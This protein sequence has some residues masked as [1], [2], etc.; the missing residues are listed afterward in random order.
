MENVNNFN[1]EDGCT[2]EDCANHA[3]DY[4]IEIECL[5]DNYALDGSAMN[6][7]ELI[8]NIPRIADNIRGIKTMYR[9]LL[10]HPDDVEN[11]ETIINSI[12]NLMDTQFGIE[13]EYVDFETI[14]R[15]DVAKAMC[16]DALNILNEL[17]MAC[18]VNNVVNQ[19]HNMI[20]KMFGVPDMESAFGLEP[21][22]DAEEI[23]KMDSAAMTAFSVTMTENEYNT[24]KI[25]DPN[26]V[27]MDTVY[28]EQDDVTLGDAL[29]VNVMALDVDDAVIKAE[30]LFEAYYEE[31]R[32]NPEEE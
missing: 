8:A 3:S 21:N 20:H 6:W 27:I 22:N 5:N 29:T 26:S 16:F 18:N 11:T 4:V 31:S 7:N 17:L 23:L 13:L 24:T 14:S 9:L 25:T 1:H 28:V 32:T 30:A 12:N 10:D 19:M 2:C 15:L